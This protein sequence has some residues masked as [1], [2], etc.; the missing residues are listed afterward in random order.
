M[1]WSDAPRSTRHEQAFPHPVQTPP[2]V[3]CKRSEFLPNGPVNGSV[4][5]KVGPSW[6]DTN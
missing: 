6:S 5:A 3:H 2:Q 1:K 4:S